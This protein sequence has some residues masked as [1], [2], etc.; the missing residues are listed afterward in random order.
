[1][2]RHDVICPSCDQRDYDMVLSLPDCIPPFCP[3]CGGERQI[4]WTP[5][6]KHDSAWS[7]KDRIVLYRN[8]KTGEPTYPGRNDEPMPSQLKAQGYERV[9]V[10]SL[11]EANRMEREGKVMCEAMH[12][13]RNGKAER[14]QIGRDRPA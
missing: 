1:M 2:P 11:S 7:P 9:E 3:S 12:Y 6:R 8:P 5:R 14:C 13:D 4:L 10:S